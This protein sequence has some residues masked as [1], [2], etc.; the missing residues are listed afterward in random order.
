MRLFAAPTPISQGLSWRL[1]ALETLLVK[2]PPAPL[3]NIFSGRGNGGLLILMLLFIGGGFLAQMW[4]H[5]QTSKGMQY[6]GLGL[7]VV[8]EAIIFFPLM[9]IATYALGDKNLIPTAG[10]LTLS[11]FAGLTVSV[12]VTGKDH[13]ALGPI[14]SVGSM[15]ALGVIVCA[16]LFGFSLGLFFSFAMVALAAGYILYDTS[17]VLHHY[18]TDQH[19]G[20]A[21][22]LFADVALLF[23]YI[24]RIL[25][26]FASD[27]R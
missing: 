18:R 15:I 3:M 20:A 17:N 11:I 10:I 13:S 9:M 21:L 1:P 25:M 27:R 2:Y 5:S 23:Y 12:F 14:L 26:I 24:L 19:V 16:M 7:Y 6:L 4:A 8:L 22:Q